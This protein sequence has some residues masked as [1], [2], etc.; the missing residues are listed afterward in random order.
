VTVDATATAT[1][2]GVEER[3]ANRAE[4]RRPPNAYRLDP[5]AVDVRASTDH[6]FRWLGLD[7]LE[8]HEIEF[9]PRGNKTAALVLWEL[10][11]G[12]RVLRIQRVRRPLYATNA[13]PIVRVTTYH[14]AAN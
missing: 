8:V 12:G 11:E 13:A 2:L 9:S 5:Q 1:T 6:T 4:P 14:R 7:R 3:W 10:T